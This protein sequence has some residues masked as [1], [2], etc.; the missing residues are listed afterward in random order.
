MTPLIT[1]NFLVNRLCIVVESLS[2]DQC[3]GKSMK[4]KTLFT[5]AMET[6]GRQ[7]RLPCE[8]KTAGQA[9]SSIPDRATCCFRE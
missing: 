2:D 1:G 4:L 7:V 6:R 9:L 5:K 8:P 3:T